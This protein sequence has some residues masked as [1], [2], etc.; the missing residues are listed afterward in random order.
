VTLRPIAPSVEFR[1]ARRKEFFRVLGVF[2]LVFLSPSVASRKLL[3]IVR[4]SFRDGKNG[5]QR[6]KPLF[7][8][9]LGGAAEAAPFQSSNYLNRGLAP[10]SLCPSFSVHVFLCARPGCDR[11]SQTTYLGRSARAWMVP[12]G[13]LSSLAWA[14][15][16]SAKAFSNCAR[17]SSSTA[18]WSSTSP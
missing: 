7:S 5:P 11:D 18:S 10:L 15:R 13:K 8:I 17:A 4:S 12:G 6:L 3:S 16:R 2:F 9:V 14:A 1:L